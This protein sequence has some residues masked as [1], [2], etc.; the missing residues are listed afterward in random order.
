MRDTDSQTV[1][2]QVLT[3][4]EQR[5]E[6]RRP[7]LLQLEQLLDRPVVTFFTSFRYPVAIEDG[8][9]DMLEGVLR[10]LDLGNGIALV[11]NSPGGD[12]LAAERIVNVCRSYSGTGEYWAIVPNKAKSAATMICLGA[13]KIFMGPTSELGLVDPQVFLDGKWLSVH[14]VIESYDSL[15]K[16]AVKEKGN[17]EPYLQQL[18][19]YD[20]RLIKQFRAS[21]ALSK[22]IAIRALESGMMEGL[23]EEAIERKIQPF[24]D[25]K[26]KKVHGRPVYREETTSLGLNVESVGVKDARWQLIY[27]LY[28]RTNQFVSR[29][30]S[31]CIESKNHSFIAPRPRERQ[32]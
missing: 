9:A 13:S 20:E 12:G 10:K 31:K 1:I 27:E 7:I 4:R 26:K 15:F 29:D 24:L 11:I 3:E 6:T 17:L 23:S 14:N 22:D 28:I 8:D 32:A 5:H 16:R 18:A 21:V 30:A 25:P 2:Q 19:N